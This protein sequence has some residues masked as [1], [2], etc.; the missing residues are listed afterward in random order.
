MSEVSIHKKHRILV[1]ERIPNF[2]MIR[3]R[4]INLSHGYA[5]VRFDALIKC[6]SPKILRSRAVVYGLLAG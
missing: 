5:Q 2:D 6:A 1:H 4:A 3:A